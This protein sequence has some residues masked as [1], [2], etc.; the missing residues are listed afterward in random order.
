MSTN[1]LRI[2]TLLDCPL[3]SD[4][5]ATERAFAITI[6]VPRSQPDANRLPLN[7]ALVI[8][9]SGSMAGLK[10]DYVKR[11]ACHL[12]DILQESDQAAVVVYDDRIQVLAESA[13]LDTTRR[14][15]LKR[16]IRE[17]HSGNS[18]ALCAG[19]LTGAEQ[20]AEHFLERGVNRTLLLTDGLA[21]VG[22]TSPDVIGRHAS[23]LRQRGV[24]TSTFGVGADYNQFLLST[25]AERGGGQYHFIE[26]PQ[27]IPE[28]FQRELGELL[29]IEARQA[30]LRIAAPEGVTLRLLGDLPHEASGHSLQIPLGD[31]HAGREITF[32]IEVKTKAEPMGRRMPVALELNS[33]ARDGARA[34]T[35]SEAMFTY[36]PH[37]EAA[38]AAVDVTVR[39]KVAEMEMAAAEAEALAMAYRGDVQGGAGRMRQA[40]SLHAP[41]LREDVAMDFAEIAGH[42]E[43]RMVS[44]MAQKQ[45]HADNYA[46]RQSRLQ[47]PVE[48]PPPPSKFWVY[49]NKP[50]GHKVRIHLASCSFC[51]DGRGIHAHAGEENGRWIG[52]ADFASALEAAQKLNG[53]LSYCK[54]CR[55]DNI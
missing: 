53:N 17:M 41:S 21:N 36:A 9:R 51:N 28:M 40:Y 52:F 3:L 27:Q 20:V 50:D 5:E 11:A 4:R 16:Q 44:P 29:A 48:P 7:L 23:E 49:E 46:R 54:H 6:T 22:E 15:A 34:V 35:T 38:K 19:W 13:P 37:D 1:S 18:T 10:L 32:V 55:P 30:T 45:R 42:F 47:Q 39:Q 43:E 33:I 25:M 12:L 8:D 2:S 14:E 31:L 26:S 24:G